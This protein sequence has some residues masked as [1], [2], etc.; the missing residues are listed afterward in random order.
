MQLNLD[1]TEADRGT[2]LLRHAV[3]ATSR[4]LAYTGARKVLLVPTHL[5][6]DEAS[7]V[8]QGRISTVCNDVFNALAAAIRRHAAR[9][10][11]PRLP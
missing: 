11:N 1:R 2:G 9:T 7:G 4:L 3:G 8:Q 5:G 6:R 10:L